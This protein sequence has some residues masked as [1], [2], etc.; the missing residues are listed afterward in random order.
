MPR[1]V[2][3]VALVAI[4][5]W[6]VMFGIVVGVFMVLHEALTSCKRKQ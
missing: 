3:D 2:E 5:A 1:T 4:S 6:S